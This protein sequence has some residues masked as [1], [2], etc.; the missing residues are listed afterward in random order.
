MHPVSSW[1][2][3]LS[4]ALFVVLIFYLPTAARREPPEEPL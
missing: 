3:V 4:I 1:A 2:L